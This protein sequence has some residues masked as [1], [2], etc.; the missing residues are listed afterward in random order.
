MTRQ[1][2]RHEDQTA[3]AKLANEKNRRAPMNAQISVMRPMKTRGNRLPDL[4]FAIR[5]TAL[6]MAICVAC[7]LAHAQAETSEVLG[8]VRDAAAALVP[9]AAV[10]LTNRGTGIQDKATTDDHGDYDFLNVKAGAY[11][12]AVEHDGFSKFTT[13][14]LPG[15][16]YRG[17]PVAWR[18]LCCAILRTQPREPG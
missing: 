15:M 14:S 16:P 2:A 7:S 12:V 8:T 4:L 6:A 11:D 13:D 18:P 5:L 9:G 1:E 3:S 17:P 10:T